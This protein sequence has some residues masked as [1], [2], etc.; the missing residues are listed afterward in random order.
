MLRSRFVALA[1][2]L[3]A[4]TFTACSHAVTPPLREDEPD[5]ADEYYAMKRQT[6]GDPQALYAA[7]RAAMAKLPRYSTE[8]DTIERA[9]IG[10]LQTDAANERPFGKW[11]SLGP[12]NIGGRTRVLVFDPHNPNVMY[13]GGV[14]GGVWKTITA[15]AKWEPLGD[16]MAN[17]TVNSL[18]MDPHDANVLYAGTGEGYF[19]E[20]VRGTA[21][22]LRGDGIFVT[23]DAGATWTQL[24]STTN[25]DFQWVNSLHVSAHDSHRI[26]AATRTG[27]WRSDDSGA[28][29]T[30][31]IATTVKG[32]CLQLV[33][34][35][36]A[37]GD[38]LYAS[39][40]T[41]D[42]ATIYRN[43]QAENGGTWEAVLSEPNQGRTTLAIAPSNPSVIYALSASNQ[44]GITTYQALL[45]VYR[46]DAS[47]DAGSWHAQITNTSSDIG[48]LLLTNLAGATWET[49]NPTSPSKNQYTT[50]GW[51]CNTIAVD[52]LDPERVWAGGVDLMRSDDGGKTWGVASYWWDDN[53]VNKQ[54]MHGDNHSIVFH[55]QYDGAANQTFYVAT[56]GG[57]WRSDNA[58]AATAHGATASCDSQNSQVFY[59][60]LNHSY[61]VTQFY[62]GAVSR[63]GQYLL[64][65]AQDN[66][67]LLANISDGPEAWKHVWGGDGGYNGFDAVNPGVLYFESQYGAIVRSDQGFTKQAGIGLSDD[68]LFVTPFTA[69]PNE[70]LRAW[71]GGRVL[72][73]LEQ[74]KWIKASTPFIGKISAIAVAPGLSKRVIA[75][76]STGEIARNDNAKTATSATKWTVTSPRAGFVSSIAFDPTNV[77]TVYATYAGFEGPHVYRSTNAGATWQSIDGNLPAIPTHSLAVD[78]T[79]PNRLYLGTDLGVFVSLDNGANWSVE[80][81]GFAAV[82]TEWLTIAQGAHGPAVYAFT[83]GRGAWRAELV[84]A[85]PRKRSVRH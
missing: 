16:A 85:G 83:H 8:S 63:D 46:S 22:P 5:A 33:A 72:W 26:Y 65:G 66:G 76:T 84:A 14:S 29:W 79:R 25:T 40:G 7:A 27:V 51:Y 48:A 61:G 56:D 47:G 71:T 20:E 43:Q 58:R 74:E 15:G 41:L 80:N 78:P 42:Q 75:G 50:M 21:L 44:P 55:P 4:V 31:V 37:N 12:G 34:K 70:S 11:Q 64:A 17:L 73:R 62:H 6:S 57:I 32:G 36:G 10:R 38:Y 30:R 49:C 18:V 67:T 19:R 39:C 81:T 28:N 24:A 35:P 13:S 23:R 60:P 69:D 52:P 77:D 2:V 45:A 54:A 59:T 1:F 53:T 3:T 68:F 9:G 82:V